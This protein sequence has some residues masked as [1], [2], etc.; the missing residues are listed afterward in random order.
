MSITQISQASAQAGPRL[1]GGRC[2]QRFGRP[3]VAR[4]ADGPVRVVARHLTPPLGAAKNGGITLI[5]VA[6]DN[7][8]GLDYEKIPQ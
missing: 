6:P 3:T 7:S 5:P 1:F 4:N 2:L 8:S